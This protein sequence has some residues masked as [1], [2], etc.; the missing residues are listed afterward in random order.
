MTN[1]MEKYNDW[2]FNLNQGDKKYTAIF[3]T[4]D[5]IWWLLSGGNR[6]K[7]LSFLI[8]V[9]EGEGVYV[10]YSYSADKANLSSIDFSIIVKAEKKMIFSVNGEYGAF[11]VK[12]VRAAA[13]SMVLIVRTETIQYWVF[14]HEQSEKVYVSYDLVGKE[15]DAMTRCIDAI[16]A[17]AQDKMSH[18]ML[19]VANG[20]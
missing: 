7:I 14:A 12:D 8:L 20:E 16:V 11:C 13:K 6:S 15:S 4:S 1:L 19:E 9:D 2:F 18:A 5:D 17:N 3:K 10:D